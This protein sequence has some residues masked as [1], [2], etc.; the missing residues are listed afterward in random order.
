[1]KQYTQFRKEQGEEIVRKTEELTQLNNN[2][3]NQWKEKEVLLAENLKAKDELMVE[4][5][6]QK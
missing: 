1:M 3:T 5:N 2:L 4:I 6:A